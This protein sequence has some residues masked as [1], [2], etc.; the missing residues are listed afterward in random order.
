MNAHAKYK[1]FVDHSRKLRHLHLTTEFLDWDQKVLMPTRAVVGRAEQIAVL[2]EL[3]HRQ[4]TDQWFIDLVADLNA[5]DEIQGEAKLNVSQVARF[6]SREM[7]VS[8]ELVRARTEAASLTHDRWL[9]ARKANSFSVVAKE[10]EQLLQL[11]IEY[12]QARAEPGECVYDALID[13]HEPEG[14]SAEIEILFAALAKRLTALLQQVVTSETFA[15]GREKVDFPL[16]KEQQKQFFLAVLAKMEF[17]L[18]AGRL[19]ETV[20]PFCATVGMHDVRLTTRYTEG[21][22]SA[23]LALIHEAGHGLYEQGLR[24]DSFGLPFGEA[25]SL[26]IHESQSLLWEKH[27]GRSREFW[28]GMLPALTAVTGTRAGGFNSETIYRAINWVEPSLNR[29]NADEVTYSLHVIIR[30]ELEQQLCAGKIPV[31]ELPQAWNEKYEKY[32]QIS[33]ADELRGVLQDTHWYGGAFGY[34]PTYTLGA[35]YAAELYEHFLK[36]ASVNSSVNSKES[37]YKA[38]RQWL[39]EKI[40]HAGRSMTSSQLM[41]Q[42]L[43]RAPTSEALIEHLTT[44]YSELYGF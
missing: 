3:T 16:S 28:Q 25:C 42:V 2:S 12:G 15:R 37:D 22:F 31:R 6:L 19:D 40:Y 1:K 34:F 29:V 11:T 7:R 17:D 36:T 5:S 44:R 9:E 10:L 23:L 43:G 24:E 14:K 33:P 38:L 32:L 8:P 4:F 13:I 27:I 30:F 21:F 26:G 20:H 39:S 41:T 18:N 35:I